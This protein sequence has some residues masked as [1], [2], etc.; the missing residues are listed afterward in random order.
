MRNN[1]LNAAVSP[2]FARV[3]GGVCR[4]S[5]TGVRVPGHAICAGFK[6]TVYDGKVRKKALS[7]NCQRRE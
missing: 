2:C 7:F 6:K 3:C 1:A 4:G 5:R